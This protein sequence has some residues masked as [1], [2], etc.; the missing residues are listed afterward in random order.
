MIA[1]QDQAYQ[2]FG[3]S[4]K[5]EF[6]CFPVAYQV[7]YRN[8]CTRLIK[9]QIEFNRTGQYRDCTHQQVSEAVYLNKEHMMTEYLPGLLLSHW[10]WPHQYRQLCFFQDQF[11]QQMATATEFLDVGV[12]SGAYSWKILQT[13]PNIQGRAIDISPASVEFASALNPNRYQACVQSIE[14]TPDAS[15]DWLV[16]VEV[17][18]HV[19]DP[20]QFLTQLHR[21]LRSGGTAF[22]SAAINAAS[23]DHIFL[24]TCTEQVQAHVKQAG[25]VV[26]TSMTTQA[27]EPRRNRTI[28]AIAG[29]L[30]VKT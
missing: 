14:Q 22:I 9:Y 30:V 18:E 6:D 15:T 7:G 2:L 23:H 25:F 28:P 12:G 1:H 26:Q 21:V 11:V 8:F 24:Y 5:Q 3:N 20:V 13:W 19:E 10:L 29:F 27:S 4:W 17:L 16:C